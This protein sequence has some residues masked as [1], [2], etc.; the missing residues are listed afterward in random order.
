MQVFIAYRYKT[1]R[2]FVLLEKDVCIIITVLFCTY[3]QQMKGKLLRACTAK[4][5]T[6]VLYVRT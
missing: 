1:I 2:T 3:V 5:A 6:Y 4:Y